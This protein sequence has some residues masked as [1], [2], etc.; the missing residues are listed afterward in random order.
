MTV[1]EKAIT[2]SDEEV[3]AFKNGIPVIK[4]TCLRT[5]VVEVTVRQSVVCPNGHTRS[6]LRDLMRERKYQRIANSV[7]VAGVLEETQ[8]GD[9]QKDI[10][11]DLE[12][13]ANL[14][15]GDVRV[16]EIMNG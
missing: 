12:Q 11:V 15:G 6:F 8:W 4:R 10:R 2:L 1:S 14:V 7:T 9:D 16:A 5:G 13:F 3:R